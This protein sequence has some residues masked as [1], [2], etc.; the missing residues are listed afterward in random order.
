ME[1]QDY[2]KRQI[3]Q[4]GLIIAGVLN[5]LKGR[6]PDDGMHIVAQACAELKKELDVDIHEYMNLS[7]SEVIDMLTAKG[8]DYSQMMNFTSM[9]SYMSE[10]LSA[11]DPIKGRMLALALDL[12]VMTQERYSTIDITMF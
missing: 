1:Q 3:D 7:A 11:D 9:L 6:R 2:L 10:A 8:F 12:S 4:I 5:L